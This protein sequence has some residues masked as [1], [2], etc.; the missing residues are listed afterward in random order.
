MN[1][2]NAIGFYDANRLGDILF[3]FHK[4]HKKYFNDELSK[5]GLNLI[6]ALCILMI[7]ENEELNQK[8]LSD[9]LYLTKGAIT[10]AVT[11]LEREKWISRE[12]SQKDKRNH[13][14][15]L[16]EKGKDF[17][18]VL[19]EINRKWGAQMGLD[20]LDPE[21]MNTFKELTL[22]SIDLNLKKE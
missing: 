18:P 8:A 6:Q 5:Y 10:K 7:F 2:E 22:K 16:T 21:F 1:F 19:A 12:K 17:L 20:E 14:L 15:K 4:N 3:I 11:K 13:V 9:G